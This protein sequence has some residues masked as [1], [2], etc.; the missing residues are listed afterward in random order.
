MGYLTAK[1]F[2]E[3]WGITERRIIKL[4]KEDRI[5]GAIKNGMVWLIPEETIKPSDKR[6]KIFKY[7]N[8]QKRIMVVNC[9]HPIGYELIPL[10]EKEGYI[11]EGIKQEIAEKEI[12]QTIKIWQV[13]TKNKKELE[14]MLAKVDKYYDGL[15]LIDI[16]KTEKIE[17]K[18]EMIKRFSLKMS[19]ESVILLVNDLPIQKHEIKWENKLSKSLKEERGLRINAINI[20]APFN[21]KIW[22]NYQEIARDILGMVINFKNTTGAS[23][24]TDGGC[25]EFNEQGRSKPLETGKFYKAINN[26]FK[27]LNQ[28]SYMWCASIM[29][30]DEWTEEP[31]E[32]NFRINNLEAANRG[33]N[34]E[35]IFIFSKSKIKEWKENKTL[36]IYN[37]SNIKTMFVDYEEIQEKEPHLLKIVGNGWDG[38]NQET[39]IVDLPSGKKQRGYISINQQEVQKAYQCFQRL[40][41]YAKDLKEAMKGG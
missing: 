15:I 12:P 17:N 23:I 39:L 28:Q 1:Q 7:I 11:V 13:D 18:E 14:K 6:S 24:T 26:Y 35:R 37:Q 29:M 16:P 33:A 36:K 19:D 41:T 22:I 30:E 3:K 25:I 27:N 10:L 21:H 31:L 20:Q 2:S 34:I 40:K 8:K 38:I 4:C 9:N 32:M 5:N